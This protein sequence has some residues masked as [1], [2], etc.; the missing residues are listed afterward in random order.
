MAKVII[1]EPNS[2]TLIFIDMQEK[3]IKAMPET[4]SETINKQKILLEAAK[5]LNINV[6]IT[7]QY[8]KGLGYTINDLSSIFSEKWPLIEK[9]TF[10][11]MGCTEVR[12]ELQKQ[13]PE[14]VVVAGIESHVCVLQTA[15]DSINA[16]YN[17]ILLTDAVN[18]RHEIDR[19]TAMKT[20]SDAGGILMTVESLLFMLMRDSKHSA[21]RDISKLLR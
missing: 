2:T 15:I 18:S 5:L 20:V 10:S 19:D 16:G 17:T 3:L 8:P 6:I 4:I 14:T 21:F 1:P 13:P 12:M 11:A 7:E 9:N